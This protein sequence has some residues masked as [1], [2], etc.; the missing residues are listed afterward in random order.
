M[1]FA[2]K[3]N[4]S[5]KTK[6]KVNVPREIENQK[7][8]NLRP[9]ENTIKPA[10]YRPEKVLPENEQKILK[11]KRTGKTSQITRKIK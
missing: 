7:A 10:R 4:W 2:K 6:E 9:E 8:Y 3:E 5:I 1:L 11:F